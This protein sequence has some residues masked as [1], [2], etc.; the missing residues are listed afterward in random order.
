M[1]FEQVRMKEKHIKIL[2]NVR[3]RIADM[4]ANISLLSGKRNMFSGVLLVRASDDTV[5][6]ACRR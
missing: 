4:K 2:K 5:W 3:V 6:H 1:F